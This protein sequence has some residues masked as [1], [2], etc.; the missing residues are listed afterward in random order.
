MRGLVPS[1]VLAWLPRQDRRTVRSPCYEL[2]ALA[3]AN[4]QM[5]HHVLCPACADHDCAPTPLRSRLQYEGFKP[6]YNV[7]RVEPNVEIVAEKGNE[8]DQ[9]IQTSCTMIDCRASLADANVCHRAHESWEGGMGGLGMGGVSG[10]L[11]SGGLVRGGVW[12]R[13]ISPNLCHRRKRCKLSRPSTLRGQNSSARPTRPALALS[14]R[15]LPTQWGQVSAARWARVWALMA[16]YIGP[17]TRRACA[18]GALRRAML[19]CVP[20]RK[21]PPPHRHSAATP[22]LCST[23]H[24]GS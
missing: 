9:Y 5:W 7:S 16:A 23:P 19:P 1:E 12:E 2:P 17:R 18:T 20:G 14:P 24:G 15:S 6:P 11:A 4:A 10:G 21:A 22:G 8:R 13:D 3:H